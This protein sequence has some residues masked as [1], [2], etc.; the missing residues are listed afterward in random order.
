MR[1]YSRFIK[2][3]TNPCLKLPKTRNLFIRASNEVIPCHYQE[4]PFS[5]LQNGQKSQ[6]HFQD[7]SFTHL[8][9]FFQDIFF[10]LTL[11][12]FL[13]KYLVLIN[14]DLK[15]FSRNFS[16][17]SS[18]LCHQIQNKKKFFS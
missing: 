8:R 12:F 16:L 15:S 5:C 2:L 11:F 17:E 4:R 6:H 9:K 18:V 1:Q 13:Q 7:Q 10:F 14:F 3:N